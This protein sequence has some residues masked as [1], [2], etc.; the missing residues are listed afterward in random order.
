MRRTI[1]LIPQEQR[2]CSIACQSHDEDTLETI[3]RLEGR[4]WISLSEE[5]TCKAKEVLKRGYTRPY[6]LLILSSGMGPASSNCGLR[7]GPISSKRRITL[8]LRDKGYLKDKSWRELCEAASREHDPDKLLELITALNDVLE[9][10][11]KEKVNG[12][13]WRARNSAVPGNRHFWFC[14]RCRAQTLRHRK[15][16]SI[17]P[18]RSRSKVPLLR[19]QLLQPPQ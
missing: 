12:A 16:N 15:A 9:Q 19:R 10:M 6:K 11:E 18:K 1:A 5:I 7:F 2:K 8:D 13:P 17:G 3:R 4:Q 14:R